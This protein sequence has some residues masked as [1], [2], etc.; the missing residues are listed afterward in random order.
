MHTKFQLSS[1][2]RSRDKADLLLYIKMAFF[3][4]KGIFEKNTSKSKSAIF[5]LLIKLESW[6]LV[7]TCKRM[8]SWP[9]N[10]IALSQT[11][12]RWYGF[13]NFKSIFRI[14]A[15]IFLTCT[16]WNHD[17]HDLY[18]NFQALCQKSRNCSISCINWTKSRATGIA[19]HI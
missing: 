12:W 18:A 14:G 5:P 3:W 7:W 19:D 6:N 2:I 4:K 16:Y 15:Q 9:Y 8:F 11:V 10:F 1:F 17:L 13:K